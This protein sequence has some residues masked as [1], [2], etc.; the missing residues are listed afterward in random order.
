MVSINRDI[1]KFCPVVVE[2]FSATITYGSG[3][4]RIWRFKRPNP[5]NFT[6]GSPHNR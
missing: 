1:T 5:D 4:N 2:G 6:S 3:V